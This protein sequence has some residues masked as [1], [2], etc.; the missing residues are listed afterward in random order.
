MPEQEIRRLRG[1]VYRLLR[2]VQELVA[3]RGP[4]PQARLDEVVAIAERT[5]ATPVAS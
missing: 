1:E 2:I 4:L 3:M 5:E